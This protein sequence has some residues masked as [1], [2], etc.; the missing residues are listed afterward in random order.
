MAVA[1]ALAIDEA[2]R[3]PT[4]PDVRRRAQA[5]VDAARARLGELDQ[6]DE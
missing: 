4:T 2:K 1:Q 3:T 5:L 6:D